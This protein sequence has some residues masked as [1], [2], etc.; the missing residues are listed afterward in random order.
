[1]PSTKGDKR[2]FSAI[3][4]EFPK[5]ALTA[6]DER[7]LVD[8]LSALDEVESADVLQPRSVDLETISIGVTLATQLGGAV[9]PVFEKILAL[10]RGRRIKGVKI[11]LGD[12]TIEADDISPKDLQ[13]LLDKVGK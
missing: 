6:A 11:T 2:M 13:A 9:A 10:I 12:K 1:M 8:S 4:I 3:G 7:E 5:T